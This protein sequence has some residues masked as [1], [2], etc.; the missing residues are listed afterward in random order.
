MPEVLDDGGGALEEYIAFRK[1]GVNPVDSDE[2]LSRVHVA[3]P[4]WR[5]DSPGHE[6]SGEGAR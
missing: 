5:E 1:D 4:G 6:G 2:H 3:P